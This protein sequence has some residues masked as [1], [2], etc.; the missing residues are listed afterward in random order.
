MQTVYAR[1]EP[2]DDPLLV[3]KKLDTRHRD[4]QIYHDQ[5]ATRRYGRFAW[6]HA[7]PTRRNK[8]VYLD[9]CRYKLF[10]LQDLTN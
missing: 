6:H 3:G 9:C 10:W 2:A 5:T 8:Y 7:K 4:V 1:Y